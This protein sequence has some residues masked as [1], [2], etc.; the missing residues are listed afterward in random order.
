MLDSSRNM[1]LACALSALAGYV[2]GIGYLHLGGLFVSFM[3]GNST[4]LG[5]SLAAGEWPTYTAL[6]TEP[7]PRHRPAHLSSNRRPSSNHHCPNPSRP[8][9]VAPAT[10]AALS[11]TATLNIP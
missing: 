11:T 8:R 6:D 3:S 7:D 9:V 1:T 2:D 4:R 10:P 5:V